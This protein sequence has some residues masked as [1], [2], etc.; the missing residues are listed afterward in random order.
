MGQLIHLETN[1]EDY[2]TLGVLTARNGARRARNGGGEEG[3]ELFLTQMLMEATFEAKMLLGAA[4][5]EEILREAIATICRYDPSKD[6]E[7]P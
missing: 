4:R 7:Y 6:E 5:S 3:A 1:N 2:C